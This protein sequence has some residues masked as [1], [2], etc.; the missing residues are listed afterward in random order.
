M[1]R[2]ILEAYTRV[3][4]SAKIEG[5]ALIPTISRNHNLY[6]KEE[7]ARFDGVTVPLNW[8]HD[9]EKKIGTATFH[10]NPSTETVFYDGEITDPSAAILAK[11]KTLYTS[12]EATP[13]SV[14]RICNGSTDCFNMPFGLRPEGLALTETPGVLQTSVNI[15]EKYI[16]ECNDP[17][18][19]KTKVIDKDGNERVDLD[20]I[21]KMMDQF[22]N[23]GLLEA[24][25]L[26]YCEDCGKVKKKLK[27]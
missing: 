3:T 18:M 6:T 8:E 15:I 24:L 9:P 7:L 22:K 5:V 2:V 10:Y 25:D 12:I 16:E 23:I 4:E 17:E 1:N 11:N 14:Q 21:T 19:H 27:Q 13:V 20:F 26:E